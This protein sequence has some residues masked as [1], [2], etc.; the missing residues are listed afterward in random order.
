MNMKKPII[1]IA[2]NIW[3]EEGGMFAGMKRSYVNH[4]YVESITR[5]GG[6]PILLPMQKEQ[7]DIRRLVSNLDGLVLS[8]GYDIDSFLY[9]EEP[10]LRQGVVYREMDTFYL[11]LIKEAV[12]LELP[13]LGICKGMQA[14]NV[15]F[16]GTLY[17]DIPTQ[18]EDAVLHQQKSPREDGSHTIFV[19]EDSLLSSWIKNKSIVNSFHHQAL[20]EVA[21]DFRVAA[22]AKDGVVE[23]IESIKHGWIVGVQWHPEMMI[24][25]KAMMSLFKGFIDQCRQGE[26]Q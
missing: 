14:L 16:G 21:K 3:I 18:I 8:G 24:K 9:G 12:A 13:I 19:E 1:A 23:G 2:G 17:Q 4:E 6:I 7:A 25:D 5:G 10:S 20:K 15:A 26:Q 11:T 22:Y